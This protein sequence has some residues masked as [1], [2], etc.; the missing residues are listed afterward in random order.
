MAIPNSL[1]QIF[2]QRTN[3]KNNYRLL[4]TNILD[5]TD[6]VALNFLEKNWHKIK[7]SPFL[8]YRSFFWICSKI[9]LKPLGRFSGE[10]N[11]A[12]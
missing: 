2:H 3:F 12:L 9:L 10:K 4:R 5:A 11:E 8:G 6:F 1:I 7:R